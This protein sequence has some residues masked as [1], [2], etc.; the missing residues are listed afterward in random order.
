MLHTFVWFF[1]ITS[2]ELASWLT[3]FHPLWNSMAAAVATLSMLALAY[4]SPSYALPLLVAE[5]VV[6]SKGGLLRLA[7]DAQGNGGAS[8]RVLWFAAFFAGW[9]LHAIERRSRRDFVDLAVLI[10]R[11]WK[12]YVAL[13]ALLAFAF[14]R[15]WANGHPFLLADANAWGV[16]LLLIPMADLASRHRGKLVERVTPAVIAALAWIT[17]ET[18]LLFVFFSHGF[19]GPDNGIY[20]WIRRTGVGEITRMLEGQ[21]AFRIFFQSH[22]FSLFAAVLGFAMT[23]D[24]RLPFFRGYLWSFFGVVCVL[25]SFSRSI[26]IGLV[27]GGLLVSGFVVRTH[28]RD[29]WQWFSRIAAAALTAA[30]CVFLLYRLP[31]PGSSSS[32][33][34]ADSVISRAD[35]GE[36]AAAS[37]WNLLPVLWEKIRQHPFA[38]HGFG[39]TLTYQSRD[40]RA[41]QAGGRTYTTYMFEWGW[42]DL[43]MKMG[44]FILPLFA[45]ILAR[46]GSRA[47][48]ADAPDWQR[49]FLPVSLAVLA[50]V[51]FF[52]PYL[53]HPLGLMF[54]MLAEG[55]IV[56]RAGMTRRPS[57]DVL[58]VGR[59]QA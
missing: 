45:L 41:V 14:A 26:W 55:W 54:L 20:L 28:V 5:Y 2:L 7:A 6:G 1:V 36:N 33:S 53:N 42:L 19:T 24:K 59:V 25:I 29:A 21:S 13:A 4:A 40:P 10:W 3:V 43:W 8:L 31:L 56:A 39:A 16:L 32:G 58:P 51:H 38:G 15:G 12:L 23:A 46:I 27:A 49:L 47:W 44:V 50:V 37:R 52:T 57:A 22:I 18:S 9:L 48:H 17:M 35:T 30:A 11:E 34:L